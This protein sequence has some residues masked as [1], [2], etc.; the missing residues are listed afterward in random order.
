[1]ALWSKVKSWPWRWRSVAAFLIV[2]ALMMTWGWF[3]T[4][5]GNL[6]EITDGNLDFSTY[7]LVPL[8]SGLLGAY[9]G[10]SLIDAWRGQKK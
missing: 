3:R 5:L 2:Y 9:V 1:M 10:G 6:N 8:I 7:A 4:D